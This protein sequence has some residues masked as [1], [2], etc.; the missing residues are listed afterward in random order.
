MPASIPAAIPS[1]L[2]LEIP[3]NEPPAMALATMLP[4]Q[5]FA[6][7]NIY[8]LLYFLKMN[9][10][11]NINLP[12]WGKFITTRPLSSLFPFRA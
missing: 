4:V 9:L 7:S 11:G 5:Q 12:H 8:I 3:T 10:R 6:L 2:E 1:K